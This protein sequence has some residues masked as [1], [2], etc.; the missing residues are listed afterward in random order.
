MLP[1]SIVVERFLCLEGQGADVSV[2]SC[3]IE[4]WEVVASTSMD[5]TAEGPVYVFFERFGCLV[6]CLLYDV[7][8]WQHLEW[9][10]YQLL[11]ADIAAI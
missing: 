8:V 6:L 11:Q 1:L 5:S 9:L 7:L 4:K 2:G 10:K 3:L